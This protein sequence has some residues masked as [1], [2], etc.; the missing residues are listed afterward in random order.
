MASPDPHSN[1]GVF[2][3]GA[4]VEAAVAALVLLHGRGASAD[5]ILSLGAELV[6]AS[7]CCLAPQ[8]N[9]GTWYPQSFLA[10]R[11]SNQ[12]WLDSALATVAEVL[13]G[14]ARAG[15]P[16][17]RTAVLGFSQGACLALDFAARH[18][19]RYGAVVAFAG[20]LI[21]AR[22]EAL[23]GTP[24]AGFDG[25]PVFIGCGDRDAHIP[26][27]RV[28]E[29]TALLRARGAQVTERIYPGMGHGINE[30]EIAFARELLASVTVAGRGDP[31]P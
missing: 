24:S 26:V 5:D 8:A 23:G 10:P 7:W 11:A 2:T 9:G 25:A 13:D 30:D 17:A 31:T 3:A 15:M 4:A 14:L 20:G 18:P 29:T 27:W 16:A 19:Q 1:A 22:G 21:G 28:G 12:P 6:P